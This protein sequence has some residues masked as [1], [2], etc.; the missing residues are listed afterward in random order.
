MR[1]LILGPSEARDEQGERVS[2][3]GQ[4]LRTLL[5]ALALRADGGGAVPVQELIE[6]VWAGADSQPEDAP[7]ALQALVA[8]LRR[9]LG[10]E[11]V[12]SLPGGYRLRA[13]PEE[14][15]LFRFQRLVHEGDRA[16]ARGEPQYAA[17][18]LRTAL[19]LWRGPAL[20]DLPDRTSVAARASALRA[21]AVRR[22]I[23]ADL[24]LGRAS[25]VLPELRELVTEQPLDEPVRALLMRALHAVGRTAE[26]LETYESVRRAIA[27]RLGADPGPELRALHA[28]LLRGEPE[29]AEG[30]RG[31]V[32]L[33]GWCARPGGSDGGE[34]AVPTRGASSHDIAPT[35]GELRLPEG[36]GSTPVEDVSDS[37]GARE[38]AGSPETTRRAET[39]GLPEGAGVTE[40]PWSGGSSSTP[41]TFQ[42]ARIRAESRIVGG[43]GG[44]SE[45]GLGP[46]PT[47]G[48]SP[49][50]EPHADPEPPPFA[51][52]RPVPE[53]YPDADGAAPGAQR[54]ETLRPGR[55]ERSRASRSSPV[56]RPE[57]DPPS[58]S[59]IVPGTGV[60]GRPAV[61]ARGT[62]VGAP[63]R[64]GTGGVDGGVGEAARRTGVRPRRTPGNVQERLT[65]FV[66][67]E[68]ELA[69]LS[70]ELLGTRLVT[71]TGSGGSGK[72]RLA[73][74]TA[75]ALAEHYPDGVWFVGLAPLDHASALPGAALSAV[76]RRETALLAQ[77]TQGS[78]GAQGSQAAHGAAAAYGSPATSEASTADRI[79]SELPSVEGAMEPVAPDRSGVTPVDGTNAPGAG[80]GSAT[81]SPGPSAT[82]APPDPSG[83]TASG[84]R[85]NHGAGRGSSDGGWPGPQTPGATPGPRGQAGHEALARLLEHCAHRRL[86][87]ILDNCEHVI[88]AAARFAETLLAHCPD[89][90]VLATSREPLNIQGETVR[91]VEPLRP[92]SAYRLF[93]ER[94][95][96]AR[97]GFRVENDPAAVGEICRRLDG[98]PLAIELAAARLRSLAPRQ[99]ADRLDDRFRLLT[100]GSRTV[101]PRQQ[102][103][104]AVVDWSW[105]L[106]DEAERTVV[107]RLSVF[108]GGCV[109]AAAEAV[110]A[111]EDLPEG[112]VLDLVGSLVDKSILVA[113]QHRDAGAAGVRYRMLETIHEYA[114]D[115]AAEHP[116]E[117]SAAEE[118]HTAQMLRFV[119]AAEP[120]VRSAEQLDWMWRLE[121]DLDNI[122]AALHRTIRCGDHA[123]AARFALAVGWFWWLRNYRDEGAQW[124][125]RIME[126]F[127]AR[128]EDRDA[129]QESDYRQLQLLS[130]FLLAEQYSQV[131]LG[132]EEHARG[133]QALLERYETPGPESARFP[134]ILWPFMAF[135][136]EGPASVVRRMETCVEN[137]RQYGRDWDV[138]AVLLFRAHIHVTSPTGRPL[139]PSD[140][141]ELEAVSRAS[142]DRWLLCQ[143]CGVRAELAFARGDFPTARAEYAE[144]MRH[145]RE[146]GVRTEIPM[147]LVRIADIWY[148]EGEA[149]RA[150]RLAERALEDAESLGIADTMGFASYLRSL[151]ALDRGELAR[152]RVLRDAAWGHAC[153]GTPPHVMWVAMGVLDARITALESPAGDA[154]ERVGRTLRLTLRSDFPE[155]FFGHVLVS[156]A[157]VVVDTCL[158][159]EEALSA[160]MLGDGATDPPACATGSGAAAAPSTSAPRAVAVP[161]S[162]VGVLVR[163]LLYLADRHLDCPPGHVPDTRLARRIRGS[164]PP[165]TAPPV[166]AARS[167]GTTDGPSGREPGGEGMWHAEPIG[168]EERERR[169]REVVGLLETLAASRAE[170]RAARQPLGHGGPSTV[171]Q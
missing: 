38:A 169:L 107:R 17:E 46:D 100:G 32:G 59:T 91:P 57:A 104:R 2:L 12:E 41:G 161:D 20:A 56:P 14:V 4:R 121:A 149:D 87:L 94:G 15:D 58:P 34:G 130:Y 82:P 125:H 27:E 148:A 153:Q 163:K 69:S 114:R 133:A 112:A 22:R 89:V 54:P 67:R 33:S 119:S 49:A 166:P 110:C 158:T 75:T 165:P 47:E 83:R 61:E 84:G 88:D 13:N 63:Q 101:L 64:S 95:A 140:M 150:D 51:S 113:D 171:P 25:H 9:A 106:L 39:V 156:T 144:A 74:Q 80:T 97:A 35:E 28:G 36:S 77:G 30:A 86:L 76:G 126:S 103:L 98:L 60:G 127:P 29:F 53:A 151:I 167:T 66:G 155:R 6:E 168:T 78:Q 45:T 105:D 154:L 138:A 108:S 93:A 40:A 43:P 139:V 18:V 164:L 115:R 132:S 122:R 134:G 70:A 52:V 55:R 72:T 99:I 8:R 92:E 81:A 109:L 5:A 116:A 19:G 129:A 159:A 128:S 16:L 10:R 31:P 136:L 24:A 142:G 11:A 48:A 137:C 79:V 111:D 65:S 3:R 124:I 102:T 135:L 131:L 143:A 73:E 96:A 23:A 160:R 120:R 1:Y 147:I 141:S 42:Q 44:P 71:L 118:R 26:A 157:A 146:L 145:A 68:D 62:V 90:T 117:R 170:R 123:T 152:A 7:A 21:G 162:D 37:G 85:A 50:T